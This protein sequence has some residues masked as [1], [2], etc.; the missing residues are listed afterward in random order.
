MRI[1]L[2]LESVVTKP[3]RERSVVRILRRHSFR[4]GFH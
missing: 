2:D 3:G 4:E 1:P